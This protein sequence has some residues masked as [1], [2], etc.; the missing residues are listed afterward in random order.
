M[1]KTFHSRSGFTLV[2]VLMVITLSVI[3]SL[4]AAGLFYSTLVGNSRKNVESS[5]KDEGDYASSQMEFLLRNALA[6]VPAPGASD[7]TTKCQTGMNS[8]SLKGI[9]NGITTLGTNNFKIASVSASNDVRYL[10]SASVTLKNLRF[11]C[12]QTTAQAG[13]FV[14]FS[15]ELS[16]TSPSLNS[17]N[18]ISQTFKS[19][20]SL[21]NY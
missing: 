21:R 4:S 18:D 17:Q 10:T 12:T 20:V 1:Q 6:I 15:F 11:N 16:K 8:I 9:D 2:E 13:T 7:P 5:L 3:I 19:A 14:E